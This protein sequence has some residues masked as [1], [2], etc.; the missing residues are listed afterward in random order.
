M[1]QPVIR[2]SIVFHPLT[3]RPIPI[4][5]PIGQFLIPSSNLYFTEYFIQSASLLEL[6]TN[7]VCNSVSTNQKRFMTQIAEALYGE[8]FDWFNLGYQLSNQSVKESEPEPLESAFETVR[9]LMFQKKVEE[10]VEEELTYIQLVRE[11]MSDL[12]RL[13]LLLHQIERFVRHI[14]N[15]CQRTPPKPDGQYLTGSE[16][17]VMVKWCAAAKEAHDLLE[18]NDINMASRVLYDFWNETIA[19]R[20]TGNWI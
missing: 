12:D 2:E 1:L 16:K 10:K 9:W 17:W 3:G 14:D 11:K 6:G 20:N 4:S 5:S 19:K 18:E 8:E 15:W 13:K 7:L